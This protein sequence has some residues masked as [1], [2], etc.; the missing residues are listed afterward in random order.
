M[1]TYGQAKGQAK[2]EAKATVN[3]A[4]NPLLQCVHVRYIQ[5]TDFLASTILCVGI[6][7]GAV[8]HNSAQAAKRAQHNHNHD[9]YTQLTSVLSGPR[10]III[11]SVVWGVKKWQHKKRQTK[12]TVACTRCPMLRF[13]RPSLIRIMYCNSDA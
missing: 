13:V 4:M 2:G 12:N 3:C 5:I 10:E 7:D 9:D 8:L 1:I 6:V 11:A